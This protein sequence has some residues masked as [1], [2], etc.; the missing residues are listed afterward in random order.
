[1]SLGGKLEVRVFNKSGDIVQQQVKH[2]FI[3]KDFQELL[4]IG[5]REIFYR[6]LTT[7]GNMINYNQFNSLGNPLSVMLLTDATHGESPTTERFIRGNTVGY[8]YTDD[9]YGESS[10][11]RGNINT[12]ESITEP[13][14]IRLVYDFPTNTANGTFQSIYFGSKEAPI[15]DSRIF[16]RVPKTDKITGYIGDVDVYRDKV[17]VVG[18]TNLVQ[19]NVLRV[20]DKN[21]M[22]LEVT[23]DSSGGTEDGGITSVCVYNNYV[24]ITKSAMTRYGLFRKNIGDLGNGKNWEAVGVGSISINE[25]P[26]GIYFDKDKDSFIVLFGRSHTT[27]VPTEIRYYSTDW[28]LIEVYPIKSL[29]NTD[30]VISGNGGRNLRG[31]LGGFVGDGN[32]GYVQGLIE[33]NKG[34]RYIKKGKEYVRTETLMV[35]SHGEWDDEYFVGDGFTKVPKTDFFASR[36]LLPDPVTKTE[37]NTMKVIYEFRLPKTSF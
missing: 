5:M 21:T 22:E 17:Y 1:M 2:N 32:G 14:R 29:P 11:V 10:D 7:K 33:D 23:E 16:E 30:Y 3:G 13:D 15:R 4:K 24:Y 34:V 9:T 20:Y 12:E 19:G 6:G 37:S 18:N 31:H 36:T 35:N 8:A 28:D 26:V 25:H 27:T